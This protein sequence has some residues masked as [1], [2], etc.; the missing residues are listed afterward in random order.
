LTSFRAIADAPPGDGGFTRL[1]IAIAITPG[2]SKPDPISEIKHE[3]G[4]HLGVVRLRELSMEELQDLGRRVVRL[5]H[6]AYE[7]EIQAKAQV[8][9]MVE[10][11][12]QFAARQA[13]GRNPRKFIRL[14]LEKL[15]GLYA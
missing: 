10:N 4:S 5:Y 1:I 14:L 8:F 12:V 13:E 11:C 7:I 15:D 6:S 3:L 9:E 2:A